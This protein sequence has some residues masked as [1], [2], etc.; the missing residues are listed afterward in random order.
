LRPASCSVAVSRVVSRCSSA[1]AATRVTRPRAP[2]ERRGA[3]SDATSVRAPT[4]VVL[5]IATW[6]VRGEL[7]RQSVMLKPGG[8]AVV[9]CNP[10]STWTNTARLNPTLPPSPPTRG[11]LAL[12][13]HNE[14]LPSGLPPAPPRC[15]S[16]MY[17]SV[18]DQRATFSLPRAEL[19][20]K[21]ISQ[22][23]VHGVLHAR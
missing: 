19:E 16:S 11:A 18:A 13:A 20:G 3:T 9:R 21:I 17:S 7:C 2:A 15:N 5:L 1:A 10:H 14:T 12:P 4:T 23:R 22:L 6:Y 8:S